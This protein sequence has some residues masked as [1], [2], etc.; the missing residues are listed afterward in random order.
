MRPAE[1]RSA[2]GHQLHQVRSLTRSEI[3]YFAAAALLALRRYQD[4]VAAA[5]SSLAAARD[6]ERD[7][8]CYLR[9]ELEAQGQLTGDGE[10]SR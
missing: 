6:G 10:R 3:T 8:L 7:P 2:H 5:R 9:D 4:L 1:I